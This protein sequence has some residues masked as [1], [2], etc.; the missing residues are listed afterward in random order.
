MIQTR[1]TNIDFYC[2]FTKIKL[3]AKSKEHLITYQLKTGMNIN[4]L[5]WFANLQS[6]I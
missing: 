4:F 5:D 3:S 6:G 1:I 2:S